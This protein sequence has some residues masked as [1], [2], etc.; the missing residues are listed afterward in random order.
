MKKFKVKGLK[1]KLHLSSIRIRGQNCKNRKFCTELIDWH[2]LNPEIESIRTVVKLWHSI[3]ST[4]RT[5]SNKIKTSIRE[6]RTKNE[7]QSL[8]TEVKGP[9]RWGT[10]LHID[11]QERE[12]MW[13]PDS[14]GL[15]RVKGSPLETRTTAGGRAL[16]DASFWAPLDKFRPPEEASRAA[17][18]GRE[19]GTRLARAE[20][21]LTDDE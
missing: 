16:V 8:G 3:N 14:T 19:A 2:T 17:W 9:H 13:P 21:A 15:R 12:K 11:V 18:T 4:R 7:I 10:L 6:M 1:C 20:H 5:Q